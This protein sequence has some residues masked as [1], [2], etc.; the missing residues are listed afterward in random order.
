MHYHDQT[1]INDRIVLANEEG[2]RRATDLLRGDG[3]CAFPT[4][5][6]YGLGAHA[7]STRAVSTVYRLKGRPAWN[8]LIVH[9]ATAEEAK[10]LV[11]EW[12]DTAQMLAQKFWPGPLTM[13]LKRAQHLPDLTATGTDTIAIRV[14]THPV[15]QALLRSCELPLAAPS[16]N[17]SESISPTLPQH[18][19]RSIPDVP[20]VLDGGPCSFGIESTVVD[21]TSSPPRLLRP[22]ALNLRTIGD[23]L[24]SLQLPDAGQQHDGPPSGSVRSPG[25]ARRH[26]APHAALVPY[27]RFEAGRLRERPYPLGILTYEEPDQDVAAL[28]VRIELLSANPREYAADLYAALHRLDDAGVST[29][30]LLTPPI[31]DEWLAIHDRLNRASAPKLGSAISGDRQA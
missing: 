28:A 14:P 30:A 7:F 13:V 31:G 9:V 24:S 23:V 1:M 12:P 25:M 29:I 16:A 22:G 10:L 5:T 6:V 8:P 20:L 18:V 21:L 27:E 2:L 17:R 19:L 4:E 26:Y 11:R 15:A 3:V